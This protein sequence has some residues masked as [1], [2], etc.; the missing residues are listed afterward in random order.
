MPNTFNLTLK[1]QNNHPASSV[2]GAV[3]YQ[4]PDCVKAI[5]SLQSAVFEITGTSASNTMAIGAAGI[6]TTNL[7]GAGAITQKDPVTGSNL[8][9]TDFRGIFLVCERA[10]SGTAP[11]VL[12]NTDAIA[13]TTSLAIG[14]GSKVFT[15]A[16][17]LGFVAG[18]RVRAVSGTGGGANYMEGVVASY[19]STTLTV[20]VDAIGGSGNLANWTIYALPVAQVT[21]TGFM[22]TTAATAAT[23]INLY[24]GS[25]FA[26]F[27]G[28]GTAISSVE[29]F[30]HAATSGQT[31]T[32]SLIGTTGLKVSV[33]VIG[34]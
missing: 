28:T 32:V 30:K 11:G 25:S 20:T 16:S 22:L 12:A 27:D 21:S 19:S 14:T 2:V 9:F 1:A 17:G 26:L 33:F 15:T 23:P 10:A 7:A 24:E 5:Q 6:V 8:A 4:I 3:S 18:Q 31:L 34:S 13:S 29:R